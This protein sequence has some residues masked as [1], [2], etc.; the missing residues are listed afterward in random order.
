[1]EDARLSSCV[2]GRAIEKCTQPSL[3]SDDAVELVRDIH[4]GVCAVRTGRGI[5]L[6]TL[7]T[8]ESARMTL[9]PQAEAI[10]PVLLQEVLRRRTSDPGNAL[11]A[12]LIH[13]IA[14]WLLRSPR[15]LV[16]KVPE[17]CRAGKA[18]GDKNDHEQQSLD[19][20]DERQVA[21]ADLLDG[22]QGGY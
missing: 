6:H 14:G 16:K 11:C 15:Q 3:A 9:K 1:M 22:P 2:Q 4:E 20:A 17:H 12:A 5:T 8:V 7:G 21:C 19:E 10:V 13:M 18:G